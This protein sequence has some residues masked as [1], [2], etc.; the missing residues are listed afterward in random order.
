ML[1]LLLAVMLPFLITTSG[2]QTASNIEV[3]EIFRAETTE[4][5][6]AA[7]ADGYPM[8]WL[9]EILNDESIPEEDRYWLD[10]RVRAEIAQDLHLF[11]NENGNPVHYEADRIRSGENYWRECF[12][13]NL[14]GVDEQVADPPAGN[15]AGIGLLVDRYGNEIGEIV[16]SNS[17]SRLARDGSVGITLSGIQSSAAGMPG[18]LNLCFFYPDESFSEFPIHHYIISRT[19]SESGELVAASC[20]DRS[21]NEEKVHKLYVFDGD[22]NLLFEKTLDLRANN[23]SD[24]IAISPDDHYIAVS[25]LDFQAGSYPVIL[26]DVETG[27]ELYTWDLTLGNHLNFSPDSRYLCMAGM[28]TGAIVDCE[29]GD[30]VWSR[31]LEHVDD[32]SPIADTEMVRDLYCTN[33]AKIVYWYA[34][35]I[36]PTAYWTMLTKRGDQTVIDIQTTGLPAISPNGMIYV[37]QNYLTWVAS[38]PNNPLQFRVAILMGGE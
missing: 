35:K 22:A 36:S 30:I 5:L 1:N 19:V 31:Y 3:V 4:E 8:P 14:P 24:V 20:Y 13:V 25:T 10:C 17:G 37:S 23:G 12:I 38:L 9:A 33:G 29:T 32:R 28:S 7:L 27:K 16:I 26:F 18:L 2:D 15:W 21:R 11:F 6:E 34:E